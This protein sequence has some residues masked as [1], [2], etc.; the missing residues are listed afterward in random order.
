MMPLEGSKMNLE[1]LLAGSVGAL[2]VF[3][4]G[5]LKDF[6]DR[7]R[8][9]RGL[10]RIVH[11]EMMR[12][13]LDLEKYY[14]NPKWALS[15]APH[16]LNTDSWE[17]VRVRLA[18]LMPADAFGAIAIYYMTIHELYRAAK[19]DGLYSNPEAFAASLLRELK[20]QEKRAEET[21]LTYANKGLLRTA[22]LPRKGG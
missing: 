2:S 11:I 3:V 22:L 9:L 8:E 16:T 21:A 17:D 1:V 4:L 20:H 10:A 5:L 14:E 18:A 15:D 6:R 12:N 7:Q 13:R 19:L